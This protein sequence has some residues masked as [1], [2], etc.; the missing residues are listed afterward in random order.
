MCSAG[1]PCPWWVPLVGSGLP[2]SLTGSLC[3]QWAPCSHPAGHVLRSGNKAGRGRTGA[4]G[5]EPAKCPRQVKFHQP[6]GTTRR[7]ADTQGSQCPG[8]VA[9]P[10]PGPRHPCATNPGLPLVNLPG[11]GPMWTAGPSEAAT[12]TSGPRSCGLCSALC[13]GS[14]SQ[15]RAW[16]SVSPSATAQQSRLRQSSPW[17]PAV[18]TCC[19][20]GLSRGATQAIPPRDGVP[21]CGYC[22]RR[23]NPLLPEH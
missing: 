5:S 23:H 13:L 10:E 4:G 2:L 18:P 9:S 17:A 22:H 6:T 8:R 19:P 1:S 21:S 14:E 12:R 16:D 3:Q 20:P 7:W 11:S 15:P